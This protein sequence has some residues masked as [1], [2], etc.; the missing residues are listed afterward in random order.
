MCANR[1]EEVPNKR[2]KT[3]DQ[4]TA[5]VAGVGVEPGVFML[6]DDEVDWE[7]QGQDTALQHA[8]AVIKTKGD[9]HASTFCFCDAL[10]LLS[11][12]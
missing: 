8:L 5:G 4:H 10:H 9:S 2:P 7:N 3:D 6:Q 11:A 1:H 12:C